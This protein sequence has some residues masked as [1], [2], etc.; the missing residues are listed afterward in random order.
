[1]QMWAPAAQGMTGLACAVC[2]P[3]SMRAFPSAKALQH[4]VRTA[5]ELA[6][7]STC[8]HVRPAQPLYPLCLSARA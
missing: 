1:M 4:H 5:H 3:G 8:L 6:L 7:C 2:D